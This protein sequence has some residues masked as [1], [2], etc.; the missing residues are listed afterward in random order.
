MLKMTIKTFLLAVILCCS[1][2]AVA[3]ELAAHFIDVGHGDAI[4]L[5][6]PQGSTMLVDGGLPSKGE[7]VAG[8]LEEWGVSYIDYMMMTHIHDDHIGGLND[9]LVNFEV[10]KVLMS[11][12]YEPTDLYHRFIYLIDSLQVET[13][14]VHR[15][16]MLEIDGLSVEIINPPP[17]KTMDRLRGPNGASVAMF[18]D[19]GDTDILLAAD[20]DKRTD[21]E[22]VDFYGDNLEA[23]VLKVAHHASSFSTTMKFLSA[24]KP[25][26]AIVSCGPSEWNYPDEAT[27]ARLE[28]YVPEVYRTDLVGDIIIIIDGTNMTVETK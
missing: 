14:I 24:V 27:M 8:Y 22:I 3:G 19:F 23:V 18:I 10:G 28:K 5:E 21:M 25:E 4:F 6:F 1:S 15:G 26:V 11:E 7:Y 16:E 12:Y 20:I 9:V 2:P 17:G 13:Q